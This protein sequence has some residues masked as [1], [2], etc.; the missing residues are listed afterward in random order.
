ML[1]LLINETKPLAGL[2]ASATG[3]I[4]SVSD[5]SVADEG[6]AVSVQTFTRTAGVITDSFV[7]GDVLHIGIGDGVNAP[8]CY[9]ELSSASPATG[10]MAINTVGMV[11]LFAAT[12]ANRLSLQ[13]GVVRTRGGSTNTIFSAPIVIHRSVI[14]IAT[15]V[16]TPS[17]L[18]AGVADALKVAINTALGFVRLDAS[19]RL[20]AVDG[21]QLT[22]LPNTGG[23]TSITGTANEITVTG[24]TTPTLSLPSA[25]TF[26]GKTVTGGTFTEGAF[27][28]TVG[29]TTP[30]TGV[31]T[32]LT[33]NDNSTL[34]SNNSDTVNFNARVASDINPATDNLYDLGVTGHEWRNLNIDGTANIDSL[35]ADTADIDGGTID[36][37]AIGGTTPSTVAGT[38]ATFSGA[39]S[40]TGAS[41]TISTV[42]ASAEIYTDGANAKI[43]TLG[44][45]AEIYT[46]G[47]NAPIRTDGSGA[48]IFT[49]GSNASIYTA[50]AN[51]PI[52]TYGASAYIQTRNTFRISNGANVTTLAAATPT[53]DYTL[54]IPALTVNSTAAVLERAQTFTA[55]QTISATTSLLLGT[56]GSAV[57]NIGFRNADSGTT[58]LQPATGALGTGTVTLPL[59]GTLAT[60]EGSNTYTGT[61]NTF[62][63]PTTTG[64]TTTSG[65]A[66]AANSL[67][68]GTGAD[69]SSTSASTTAG[70]VVRIA[71][72]G[73]GTL[74]QALTLTASGGTTNTALNVTAGNTFLAGNL[75]F[76]D[77]TYD[78]G[79][80]AAPFYRVRHIYSTGNIFAAQTSFTVCGATYYS[81]ATNARTYVD[82]TGT[83]WIIIPRATT[84]V[85][86][87]CR[88]MASQTA[89][90]QRWT[91]SSASVLA[92]IAADGSFTT[93]G[94]LAVT[95]ATTLTGNL[96]SNGA[97]ITTPQALSG[98]GAV[99]VT[100][101]TTAVTTTAP[102]QALTLADG[103]NGQ[104]KTIVH[105]ALSGGGTWVLTPTTKTGYTTITSSAVGDTCTLQ[106]FTTIGWC[107]LSLRGAI[108][109]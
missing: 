37:T 70:Q 68:T 107:I 55:S 35:V 17:I 7:A 19:A 101:L 92:K 69:F 12:V 96:T 102:A 86:F 72:T 104:I 67:T 64:T 80:G 34:G 21:S 89:D 36:G 82:T 33:V 10:T 77:N 30:T 78:I 81:D 94:T 53:G 106:F 84:A 43:S 40:T 109:A 14:N 26:T 59:S 23:V 91:D 5:I 31:F 18:G 105:Q 9:V 8:V 76:T 49:I 44:V 108:A 85:P 54:T 6:Q 15:A 99:N 56:A 3:G 103:T 60:L 63:L 29:A 24:T 79:N 93:T 87:T 45:N 2:F 41:A 25:L 58:T 90:L 83:G 100:T 61:T 42:G 66:V 71:K 46:L 95:G 73:A 32:G 20:P 48:S 62:T 75:L 51:A 57:G 50:G 65:I 16:P 22:N 1:T 27:N 97:L 28:G 52:V 38:T 4:G 47:A 74:N 98:A 13:V 88:G 11:A 39:V